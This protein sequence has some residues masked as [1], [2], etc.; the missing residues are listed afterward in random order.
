MAADAI[1]FDLIG[2]TFVAPWVLS[3][4]VLVPTRP[5][6]ALVALL[7]SAAA[8]PLICLAQVPAGLLWAA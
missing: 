1:S 2:I 6:E 3:F 4:S 5:R 8:V 7:G